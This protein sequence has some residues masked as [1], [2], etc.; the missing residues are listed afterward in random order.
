MSYFCQLPNKH[1]P[2]HFSPSTAFCIWV[3][4]QPP[5]SAPQNLTISQSN[6]FAVCQLLT[7]N[8]GE[9]P[10]FQTLPASFCCGSVV[11]PSLTNYFMNVDPD[12][13]MEATFCL[14][15]LASYKVL[16][17]LA[18]P[19]LCYMGTMLKFRRSNCMKVELI[20]GKH[21]RFNFPA[22]HPLC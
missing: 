12:T 16:E 19:K 17:I 10:P 9:N 15:N 13:F 20:N 4:K 8:G 21:T 14:E 5:H 3:C 18:F 7:I 2:L 6:N 11:E 1:S 22:F